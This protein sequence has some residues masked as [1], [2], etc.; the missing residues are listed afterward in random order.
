MKDATRLPARSGQ[1]ERSRQCSPDNPQGP[2]IP[3]NPQ[4]KASPITIARGIIRQISQLIPSRCQSCVFKRAPQPARECVDLQNDVHPDQSDGD[5]LAVVDGDPVANNWR[6]IGPSLVETVRVIL[7]FVRVKDFPGSLYD[8]GA[9]RTGWTAF[10]RSRV[11]VTFRN[12]SA[13]C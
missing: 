7:W 3:A 12:C 10:N 4:R 5:D 13:P 6:D 8:D 11:V 9:T 2:H 1:A